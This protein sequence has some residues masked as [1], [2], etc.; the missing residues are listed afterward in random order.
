MRYLTSARISNFR[1]YGPDFALSFPPGPS[2]TVVCGMNGLGKTTLFDAIEWAMLGDI[3]RFRDLHLSETDSPLTRREALKNSHQVKL[4]WGSQTITRTHQTPPDESVLRQVLV[5]PNWGPGVRDLAVYLRLTHFLP[6]SSGQRFLKKGEKERWSLLKGPSG[7]ERIER[8]REMLHDKK[9]RNAFERRI[10][11]LKLQK[12]EALREKAAWD[13]MLSEFT[14]WTALAQAGSAMTPE[15]VEKLL[16]EFQPLLIH[17]TRNAEQETVQRLAFVRQEIHRAIQQ[18]ETRVNVYGTQEKVIPRHVALTE[19]SDALRQALVGYEARLKLSGTE[20]NEIKGHLET[21]KRELKEREEQIGRDNARSLQ[22]LTLIEAI[23]ARDQ[24]V[25]EERDLVER[26]AKLT[27]EMN[28]VLMEQEALQR[29]VTERDGFLQRASAVQERLQNLDYVDRL[30]VQ[31]RAQEQ[32]AIVLQKEIAE[33]E[34]QKKATTA[35]QAAM[36]LEL[37]EIEGRLKD[38]TAEIERSK[39][40]SDAVA[41]ARTTIVQHISTDDRVCPVCAHEHPPGE[42]WRHAHETFHA[43]NQKVAALLELGKELENQITRLRTQLAKARTDIG[44]YDLAISTRKQ[45]VA[46]GAAN[47][48]LLLTHPLIAGAGPAE[49][50]AR[51]K[52]LRSEV[53]TQQKEVAEK[54]TG[55]KSADELKMIG[56]ALELR[57]ATTRE[58]IQK[59]TADLASLKRRIQESDAKLQAAEPVI[60]ECGGVGELGNTRSA[61]LQRISASE[62]VI[63]QARSRIELLQSRSATAERT[64]HELQARRRADQAALEAHGKELAVL[65]L[66]WKSAGLE[67][68]PAASTLTDAQARVEQMILSQKRALERLQQAATGLEAWSNRKEL[69]RVSNAI[70]GIRQRLGAGT[71]DECS[72]KI[73]AWATRATEAVARADRASRRAGEVADDLLQRS[74]DYSHAALDPLGNRISAFHQLISPFHYGVTMKPHLTGTMGKAQAMLTVPSLKGTK[75]TD[76]DPDLWLSEGQA[77][78]LGLSVL[79]GASTVYRWSSWRALLLDDPLQNTDLIHAA[80][81]GDVIR[82][83][84]QDDG[85][86]VIV[87]SHN[88]DETDFLLRKVRRAGLPVQRLELLSL[89][90]DGVRYELRD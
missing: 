77:S 4:E 32:Q 42:L 60:A 2:L 21:E 72:A 78:A 79:L 24:Q 82:S 16:Q 6:Q 13:E 90:P 68:V 20:L 87:S 56:R 12:A 76:E 33:I 46:T 11:F 23:A 74:A 84:M 81:F 37:V 39:R 80:A 35:S 73:V 29:L 3:Q 88:P 67:G 28:T 48:Q 36:Q 83:L 45:Q 1:T 71:N 38:V 54:L 51:L 85:Y 43:A 26:G 58:A 25:R 5:D 41:V 9:A 27:A 61:L 31:V 86:Q 10:D 14:R 59:V 63:A 69:S 64:H 66:G 50:E 44:A 47:L 49:I 30:S 15:E 7:V 53:A 18:N 19:Q 8:F 62:S 70:S 40:A 34:D 22:L 52:Q 17:S 75:S 55:G 57:I 65:A 89:S